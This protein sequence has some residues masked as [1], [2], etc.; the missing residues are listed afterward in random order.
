[1]NFGDY[2]QL[3]ADYRSYVDTQDRVDELYEN[4]DEW[5]SC[6]VKNIANMGYFSSDRTIGE[7][8]EDIWDIKP[9]RL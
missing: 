7:Y 6:A 4:K 3:L 8:A 1:V 5:A 2:Y 9:I